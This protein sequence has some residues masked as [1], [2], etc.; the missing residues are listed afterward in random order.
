LDETHQYLE[1]MLRENQNV[2]HLL[3]S[4]YTYLNS[5]LA[6]YYGIEGVEGDEVRQVSL[7]PEDRRGGLITPG[8]IMKVTANGSTTSPVVRGVWMLEKIM[9]VHVPPPPVDVAAVEPD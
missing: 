2:R 7:K 8:S 9:G 4:D 3:T 1:T 6:R 5:R